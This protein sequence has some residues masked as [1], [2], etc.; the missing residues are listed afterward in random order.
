MELFRW[1]LLP[2]GLVFP[3]VS[4]L[5]LAGSV[6]TA[7]TPERHASAVLIP[8]FGPM[9][10]TGWILLSGFS[11]LWIPLVWVL[12]PGTSLFFCR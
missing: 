4:F 10:L 1:F 6:M 8:F 2:V 9:V 7:K 11:P 12:D 3:F 5:T